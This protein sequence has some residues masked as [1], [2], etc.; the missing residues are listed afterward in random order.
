[1]DAGVALE[2]FQ[3]QR[4][5]EQA[6]DLGILGQLRQLLDTPLRQRIQPFPARLEMRQFAGLPE[7][8]PRAML[9][10]IRRRFLPGAVVVMNTEN[11]L[12]MPALDGRPT[13]YVCE[14]FACRL[15]TSDPSQLDELLQ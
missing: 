7:A 5:V 2:A 12:P 15:P 14:N 11:A 4:Q 9:A 6:L 10:A 3:L 8:D 1:M 13:A